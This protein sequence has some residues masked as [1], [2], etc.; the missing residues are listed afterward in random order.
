[1]QAPPLQRQHDQYLMELFQQSG[2][3]SPKDLRRLNR[4]QLFAQVLFL[5]NMVDGNGTAICHAYLELHSRC[6]P[7]AKSTWNWPWQKPMANDWLFWKAALVQ[8][9]NAS[10]CLPIW[11][12]LGDWIKPSHQCQLWSYDP[13]SDSVFHSTPLGW[14]QFSR[15]PGGICYP[16][17][18]RS[19]LL[20]QDDPGGT[21]H[22]EVRATRVGDRVTLFG[23]APIRLP[24]PPPAQ[25]LTHSIQ[26]LQAE[27][28]PL[29]LH[30]FTHAQLLAAAIVRGDAIGAS[31]GSYMLTQSR[32]HG[33][34]TW[35]LQDPTTKNLCTGLVRTSGRSADINAYRSELQG[36]HTMLL[37]VLLL[38]QHFDIE[39]GHVTLAC[40][41]EK[42][43][44]LSCNK[45]LEVLCSTAHT[46]LIRG[47]RRI[48]FQ[49]PMQITLVDI[50]GHKDDWADRASL[51]PLEQL[52][53]QMDDAAKS[54]L[55]SLIAVETT[56]GSYHPAPLDTYGEGIR[57]TIDGIKVTSLPDNDLLDTI[58]AAKVRQHLHD[59]AILLSY[60][61][62]S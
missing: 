15:I 53:C 44:Y 13:A 57:C 24:A 3:Y 30:E 29:A 62:S 58:Y 10:G 2:L 20:G 50:D 38:C 34:A 46:D 47:I 28:W 36:L 21:H 45:R 27:G 42:A 19:A 48:V 39:D 23:H 52:N 11:N 5:S 60:V 56:P 54:Y 9:T 61:R 49:I 43:I 32:T 1:M 40:D 14:E 6:R 7:P 26:A 16:L 12:C 51:T 31:D 41:N 25:S 18:H 22:A 33:T 4:C 17:Y 35:G 37:A 59:K 55:R 8:A